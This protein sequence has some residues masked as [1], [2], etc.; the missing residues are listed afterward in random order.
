[1]LDNNIDTEDGVVFYTIADCIKILGWS[2]ATVQKLFR[3]PKFPAVDFG[4]HKV[5]EANAFRQYFS[6][7]HEKMY[8]NH[9]R[10]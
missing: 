5:V 10:K 6:V 3:D 8:D 4:K 9:W 2:K 7:R 1:M